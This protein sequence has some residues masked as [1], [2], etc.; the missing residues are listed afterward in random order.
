MPF[1]WFIMRECFQVCQLCGFV[2][3]LIVTAAA[4]SAPAHLLRPGLDTSY[5][6]EP[7]LMYTASTSNTSGGLPGL[8]VADVGQAEHEPGVLGVL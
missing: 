4:G 2:L 6:E 1:L 5:H 3:M 8:D 7:K